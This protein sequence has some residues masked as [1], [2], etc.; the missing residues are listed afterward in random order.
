MKLAD[1]AVSKGQPLLKLRNNFGFQ[2]I[3]ENSYYG[4][5]SYERHFIALRN[6]VE[7]DKAV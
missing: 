5:G 1:A 6:E 3:D 2:E 4:S 7:I